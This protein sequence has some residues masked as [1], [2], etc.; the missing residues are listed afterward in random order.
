[1][2]YYFLCKYE[3]WD[4]FPHIATLPKVVRSVESTHYAKMCAAKKMESQTIFQ[5]GF[6]LQISDRRYP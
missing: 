1:M 6:L 5:N 3:L 2:E 4:I